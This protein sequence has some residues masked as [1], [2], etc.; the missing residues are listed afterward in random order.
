MA[1]S[2]GS[3]TA[4]R[5]LGDRLRRVRSQQGR[6]LYAVEQASGGT[7]KASV[8]GAYERGERSVSLSRLHELAAFYRVPV[9]ELLPEPAPAAP[10]RRRPSLVIDLVALERQ[11]AQAPRLARY[12]EG[13]RSKRHDHQ[14]RVLTV[15]ADDLEILAAADGTSPEQL[16]EDLEAVRVVR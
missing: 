8:L 12:V 14:G 5:R 3:A 15:R 6:S 4:D 2:A 16:R 9:R 1:A 7:I 10:P 11:Q 13:I